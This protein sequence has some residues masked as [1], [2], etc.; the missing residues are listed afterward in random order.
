MKPIW[1]RT[2]DKAP[3]WLERLELPWLSDY[4]KPPIGKQSPLLPEHVQ[5][6]HMYIFFF[7]A[8][9]IQRQKKKAES[10]SVK[11]GKKRSAVICQWKADTFYVTTNTVWTA[12]VV[13]CLTLRSNYCCI[14]SL[15]IQQLILFFYFTNFSSS[16]FNG[17]RLL[18]SKVQWLQMHYCSLI[19]LSF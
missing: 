12:E 5:R 19:L 6:H 13:L 4:N 2:G 8:R 16:S 15:C 17:I 11:T 3:H 1:T 18:Y 7:K 9:M 14:I 10:R